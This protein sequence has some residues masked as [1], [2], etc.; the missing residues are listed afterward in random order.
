MLCRWEYLVT[1]I[2]L[3]PAKPLFP[4]LVRA[5]AAGAPPCS[6]APR[7]CAAAPSSAG[8]EQ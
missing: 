2:A 8:A 4:M 5:A 7:L 6:Y 3:S 1:T